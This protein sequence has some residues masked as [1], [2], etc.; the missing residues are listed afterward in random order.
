MKTKNRIW[1]YSSV[2][3]GVFLMFSIALKTSAQNYI[4]SFAATGS[5]TTIDSVQVENITQGTSLTIFGNDSLHLTGTAG[6]SDLSVNKLDVKIYPNPMQGQAKLS[7]YAK[8]AGNARLIIYDISGKEVLQKSNV[9]VQGIQICLITGLKQGIYFV[10]II[11]ENYLYTAKLISLNTAQSEAKIEYLGIEKHDADAYK[12]QRTKSISNMPYTSGDTLHFTGFSGIYSS[13]ISDV[14]TSSKTITFIFTSIPTVTTDS[15]TSITTVTATSGGNVT[16]DGGA[17]VNAKGVCWSTTTN[18]VATGN[19]TTDGTGIGTF[20]SSITGLT[21]S[22]T[23]YVRAYAT[24][25]VGTA[26]GNELTFTTATPVT[27]PVVTTT[28][29]SSIM[30]TSAN[31][32]GNVTSD[33]GA[34]VTAKG[35]CWS[36]TTNPVATGSHTTNGSGTGTFTSSITGLSASTG[37]YVRAY[38]TNSVGTAYGN[39]NFFTTASSTLAIGDNYQGGIVAYL[40]QAGDPGYNASVQHGL[41]A[42]P[43]DQSTGIIWYNGTWVTTG[44]TA[45]AIGTGNANTNSIVSV[46][47][48][49]SYAAKLCYDLVLNSYSDW[50]L[51]SKDELNKL[52][53]NQTAIGGFTGGFY[54]SSTENSSD[55][56]WGQAF[57]NGTQGITTKYYTE[58]VRAIRAF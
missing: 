56:A 46:Q 53:L 44:A 58:H 19:H 31:S 52:Y 34:T 1:I 5:A 6:I 16:S 47:G 33:G 55:Y 18:P 17:T 32:G 12:L 3:L 20:T 10:N 28:A 57:N 45:T 51:P 43:S 39:Q 14:P 15:A 38:A 4:I 9:F 35:V 48:T 24:N 29:I 54:W 21:A 11:G 36:T 8:K 22:T 50:Y 49:G 37:Y 26:Y 23:Y 25:S 40:L 7:F 41:I 30:S 27:L 13:M 42:A 2:L